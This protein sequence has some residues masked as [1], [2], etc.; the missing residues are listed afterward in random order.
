MKEIFLQQLKACSFERIYFS[1]G[2]DAE[3]YQ[4]RKNA[5]KLI[6]PAVLKSIDEDT[7]NTV[8]LIFLILQKL[9]LRISRSRIS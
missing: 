7:D 2:S 5:R 6:L 1:R 8:S 9:L 4:E 3:I